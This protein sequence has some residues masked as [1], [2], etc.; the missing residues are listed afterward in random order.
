MEAWSKVKK[1]WRFNYYTIEAWFMIVFLLFLE[2]I[3]GFVM[4]LNK[5]NKPDTKEES[6][7][8]EETV[9]AFYALSPE[10]GLKEALIYY[11]VDYPDIVYSQAVLETGNFKSRVCYEYNNLFGLY[12]SRKGDY[13]RFNHWVESIVAYR[14]M[15]Q[16]GHRYEDH[17]YDYLKKIG[18]AEDKDYINKVRKIANETRDQGRYPARDTVP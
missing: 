1:W 16:G 5:S 12:N 4:G 2:W 6:I 15:I 3:V 17:Y 7:V 18:Y 9:P 10:E 13:F 14:D 8:I 11:N